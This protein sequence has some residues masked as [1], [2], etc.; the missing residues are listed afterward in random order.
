MSLKPVPVLIIHS[1]EEYSGRFR[2]AFERGFQTSQKHMDGRSAIP[3]GDTLYFITAPKS[4]LA[5]Q[6]AGSVDYP[7]DRN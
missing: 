2:K 7:I 4:Y 1:A 6:V 5:G 3:F